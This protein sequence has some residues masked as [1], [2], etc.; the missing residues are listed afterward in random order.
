VILKPLLAFIWLSAFLAASVGTDYT[1]TVP[2]AAQ[3]PV[4]PLKVVRRLFFFDY[5]IFLFRQV[6]LK[7]P[8]LNHW[9]V[10]RF[11]AFFAAPI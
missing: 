4:A 5:F 1:N 2:V 10:K 9:T 3:L 7:S 8:T 11:A 6:G